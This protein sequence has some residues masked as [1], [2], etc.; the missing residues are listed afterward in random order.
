MKKADRES[1]IG[2]LSSHYT[3]PIDSRRIFLIGV[4]LRRRRRCRTLTRRRAAAAADRDQERTGNDETDQLL[5]GAVLS[6]TD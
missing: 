2:P 1:T 3:R 5:H 6:S 4:T